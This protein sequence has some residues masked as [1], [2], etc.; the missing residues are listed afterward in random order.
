MNNQSVKKFT[1]VKKYDEFAKWPEFFH[2]SS[3]LRTL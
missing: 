3:L 1:C 2:S